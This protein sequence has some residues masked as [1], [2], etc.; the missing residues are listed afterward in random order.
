MLRTCSRFCRTYTE[1]HVSH[2]RIRPG[3]Q[4]RSGESDP[5]DGD[6]SDVNGV[7]HS[8]SFGNSVP[9][10][11]AATYFAYQS[12]QFASTCPL[13]FSNLS[14]AAAARRSA[15]ARSFADR[16]VVVAGSM[17]P[18]A[19]RD[20]LNDPCVA[21]RI[22]EGDVG[23]VALALGVRAADA[24]FRRERRTV[25]HLSRADAAR[26]DLLVG[27]VYVGDN[28]LSPERTGLGIC[29]AFAKRDGRS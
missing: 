3:Q 22:L 29:D 17:R 20:L 26:H 12:G 23:A 4:Q 6:L 18:G 14:W 9:A 15:F 13:F 27:L 16:K 19:R 1:M 24:S 28:Q 21:V 5:R 10:C 8:G 25:E 2:V 7:S 11:S